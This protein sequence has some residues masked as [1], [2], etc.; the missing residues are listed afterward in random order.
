MIT[1]LRASRRCLLLGLAVTL[2]FTATAS[3]LPA[4]QKRV[5]D[6]GV[7]YFNVQPSCS[8][9]GNT[10]TTDGVMSLRYPGFADEAAMART[11]EEYIRNHEPNS[12]WL[13][14]PDFG[15]RFIAETKRLNVNPLMIVVI[16][17]AESQFGTSGDS[18]L[19][20]FNS[21]GDKISPTVYKD[22]GSWEAS[23]FGGEG[24]P[25]QN[26]SFTARVAHRLN[27]H[28]PSYVGVTNMYEYLSV[29][30]TGSIFREGDGRV[31]TDPKMPGVTVNLSN[32]IDYHEK[33]KTWIGEMTGQTIGNTVGTVSSCGSTGVVNGSI[34]Q[35]ALALAWTDSAKVEE[36]RAAVQAT[37]GLCTMTEGNHGTCGQMKAAAGAF[38]RESDARPEYVTAVKQFN[39]GN[40]SDSSN[41]AFSDC[42]VF[43]ATVMRASGVDTEFPVRGTTPYQLPYLQT[44]PLYDT[45]LFTD[46][47]QL[48]PGDILIKPGHIAIYVGPNN[49][50]DAVVVQASWGQHVPSANQRTIA[51]D[52]EYYR[53]RK[54]GM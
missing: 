14:I 11:I 54:I 18:S 21:F 3:A 6:S 4:E 29:H 46:T 12:P 15:N 31:V 25:G 39:P 33:A 45:E 1:V 9:G 44:S 16:G 22:F 35:T 13:T 49:I 20:R 42:G 36:I 2:F 28:H 17:R 51:P 34:V 24:L 30:L 47:S 10:Y 52:G 40:D 53:A 8:I 5:F 48:Q 43:V 7:D 23:L 27:G 26:T 32:V 50:T 37:N 41:W 19:P 38:I